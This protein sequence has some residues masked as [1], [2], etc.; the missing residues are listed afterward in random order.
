VG[1]KFF[2]K[3]PKGE[4]KER[5]R[6]KGIDYNHLKKAFKDNPQRIAFNY[7]VDKGEETP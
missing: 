3:E 4:I 7:K 2:V 1:F 6:D 5:I